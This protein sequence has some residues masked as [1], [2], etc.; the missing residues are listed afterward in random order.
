MQPFFRKKSYS[1]YKTFHYIFE[2]FIDINMT[3]IGDMIWTNLLTQT[4]MNLS[5]QGVLG[6][7]NCRISQETVRP[8]PEV[9]D[10]AIYQEDFLHRLWSVLKSES[11]KCKNSFSL[12]SLCRAIRIRV[13]VGRLG[14]GKP[15]GNLN[16]FNIVMYKV[17]TTKEVMVKQKKFIFSRW[18]IFDIAS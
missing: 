12:F 18:V 5:P 3:K 10:W 15:L 1:F 7:P 6:Y 8:L 4:K 17:K 13:H 9:P 16:S 2:Q 14:W 11:Y